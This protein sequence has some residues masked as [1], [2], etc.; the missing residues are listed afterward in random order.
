MK[1]PAN[2]I[3]N[4]ETWRAFPLRSILRQGCS[5]LP[6]SFSIVLEVLA[7]AIRQENEMKV[8]QMKDIR[9][10]DAKLSILADQI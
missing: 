3:L 8:I 5:L 1:N 7:L 9:L 6:L 2:I 10:E 4:D